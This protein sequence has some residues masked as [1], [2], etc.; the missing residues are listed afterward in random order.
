MEIADM[1][2][3]KLSVK[4][5]PALTQKSLVSTIAAW[6]WRTVILR[7]KLVIAREVRILRTDSARSVYA[8]TKIMRHQ[9][10]WP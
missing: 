1:P 7:V 2:A 6:K 3:V 9:G 8:T 4:E 5:A 10:I